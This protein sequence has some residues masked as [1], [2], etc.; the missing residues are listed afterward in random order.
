[1]SSVLFVEHTKRG[2]LAK[3]IRSTAARLSSMMWFTLKIVENAG[4]SLASIFSDK[5]PWSSQRCG[6]VICNPFSQGKEVVDDC[7]KQNILYESL[8][9]ECHPGKQELGAWSS[10]IGQTR[11]SIHL[12]LRVGEITL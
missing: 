3:E 6:R 1:M 9:R 11:V 2:L 10:T 5:N 8:C 4:S 12:S 7:K